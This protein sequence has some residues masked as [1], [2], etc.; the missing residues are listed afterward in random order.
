MTNI[1]ALGLILTN[2]Q[3]QLEQ[4]WTNVGC[5]VIVQ[6]T[7][8]L[9]SPVWTNVMEVKWLD[10]PTNS[11]SFSFPLKRKSDAAFFRLISY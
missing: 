7:E 5:N 8:S 9:I 4:Q 1:L 2:C 10:C 6:A 11:R 3:G